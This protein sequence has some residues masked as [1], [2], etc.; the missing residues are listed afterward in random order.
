MNKKY[1]GQICLAAAV[2][3]GVFFATAVYADPQADKDAYQRKINKEVQDLEMK[4]DETK[5]EYKKQ[6]IDVNQEVQQYQDRIS[7]IK[8][9]AAQKLENSDWNASQNVVEGNLTK[10]RR[11][12]Y[13]WRV[14]RTIAGYRN[15]IDDLKEQ[16][17]NETDQARKADLD[18]KIKNLEEKNEIIQTRYNIL[19]ISQGDDWDKV[20]REI[21]NSVNDIERDYRSYR[22]ANHM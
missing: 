20:Q 8:R 18:A 1:N 6:G 3:V 2:L 7:E 5:D 22:E 13:E 14:K 9:N 15:K 11:D 12:F 17:R 16:S 19:A 21:D 10:I 4:I